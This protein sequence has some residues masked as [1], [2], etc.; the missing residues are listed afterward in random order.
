MQSTVL[1]LNDRKRKLDSAENGDAQSKSKHPRVAS[2]SDHNPQN[3]KGKRKVA[4]L[5][6]YR[7]TNYMGMQI[8]SKGTTIESELKRAFYEAGC[9]SEANKDDLSK[10]QFARAARTDK[11]VHAVGAVVSVRLINTC[12]SWE[13]LAQKINGKLPEDIRIISICRVANKFNCYTLCT[14]RRYTYICPSYVFEK[15]SENPENPLNSDRISEWRWNYRLSPDKVDEINDLLSGFL[16]TKL[17]HNFTSRRDPNDPSCA[18]YITYFA[19]EE[20]FTWKG[21][22]FVR[23]EVRGQSFILNQ[24]RKMV[25]LVIGAMRGKIEQEKYLPNEVFRKGSRLHVPRAP[26]L[27]LFLSGM[28]FAHHNRKMARIGRASVD[29]SGAN[30]QRELAEFRARVV[31]SEIC[32]RELDTNVCWDWARENLDEQEW[33]A[34]SAEELANFGKRVE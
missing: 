22:E 9:V 18:R 23:L 15:C 24:I 20:L 8:Q 3:P 14:G 34:F 30:V 1:G 12:D 11:G 27:G 2:G 19:V 31:E 7:G 5:L 6:A 25:G 16:G 17:Y 26:A 33:G 10:I 4:I 29:F 32:A 28:E 21:V 13:E